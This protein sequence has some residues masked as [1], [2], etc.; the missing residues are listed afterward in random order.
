MLVFFSLGEGEGLNG[1]LLH[2]RRRGAVAGDGSG[3]Y[4]WRDGGAGGCWPASSD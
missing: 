2:L 1:R 3:G 4:R